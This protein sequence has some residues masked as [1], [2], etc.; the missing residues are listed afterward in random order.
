M[1]DETQRCLLWVEGEVRLS[2]SARR[3]AAF[4]AG[5]A[6]V[7]GVVTGLTL[8]EI[9]S[10]A[11]ISHSSARIGLRQLRACGMIEIETGAGCRWRNR[12]R[13]LP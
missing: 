13:L 5:L 4:L 12:F 1:S 2:P 8:A 3:V 11:G 7:G 6:P 9:G 10:G